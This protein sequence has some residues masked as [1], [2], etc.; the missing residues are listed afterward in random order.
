M[1]GER[2]KERWE[3][4]EREGGWGGGERIELMMMMM[5]LNYTSTKI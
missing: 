2:E 4:G 5:I 3:R 1:R